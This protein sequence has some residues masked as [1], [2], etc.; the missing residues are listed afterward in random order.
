MPKKCAKMIA[1]TGLKL[2]PVAINHSWYEPS[3]VPTSVNPY[4]YPSIEQQT[5]VR[6]LTVHDA[7]VIVLLNLL[8]YNVDPP[9]GV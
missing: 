2:V 6:D 7:Q 3:K 8:N 4:N 1:F 9:Q 5:Q